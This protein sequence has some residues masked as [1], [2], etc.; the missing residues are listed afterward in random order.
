MKKLISTQPRIFI[1]GVTGVIGSG[2]SVFCKALQ[3]LGFAWVEADKFV[4]RLYVR[5]QP[6]YLKI[7]EKFGAEFV[8]SAEVDRKK[9]REFILKNPKRIRTLNELIHP[10]VAV[11]V[12]KKVDQLVRAGKGKKPIL[13]CIEAVYLDKKNLG[14][15]VD[16]IITM[17]APDDVILQRLEGRGI[18]KGELLALLKF[19]RKNIY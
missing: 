19:Q 2:K 11:D 4:H 3:K 9:L 8:N 7:K 18:K 1:L 14:K 12:N 17:D 13:I 6:G 16:K 15:F 10:L 5:G